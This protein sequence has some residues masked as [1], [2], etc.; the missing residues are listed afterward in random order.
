MLCKYSTTELHTHQKNFF[1]GF[2]ETKEYTPSPMIL[3][4]RF[5]KDRKVKWQTLENSCVFLP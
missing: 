5:F 2:T 1:E 4:D 3:T